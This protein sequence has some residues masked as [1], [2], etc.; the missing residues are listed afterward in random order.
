MI[1]PIPDSARV[2]GQ[3]ARGEVRAG[4]EGAREIATRH[5]A[6]YGNA[7]TH[8]VPDGEARFTGYSQPIPLSG[9]HYLELAPDFY[10]HVFMQIGGWLPE[11]WPSEDT[12]GGTARMEYAHLHGRAVPRELNVQVETKGYGGPRRFMKI[13][14]RKG[15]A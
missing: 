1:T 2:L 3:I 14:W 12:P 4:A 13:Q 10:G 6:A 11:G 5:E 9:W 7:F 8:H 15:G